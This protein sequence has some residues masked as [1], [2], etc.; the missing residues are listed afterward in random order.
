MTIQGRPPR[1]GDRCTVDDGRAGV[2]AA[3]GP[4]VCLI[5]F[6]GH[7]EQ[8]A[9]DRV[10]YSVA[11]TEILAGTGELWRAELAKIGELLARVDERLRDR[12]SPALERLDTIGTLVKLLPELVA[13]VALIADGRDVTSELR[14]VVA[15]VE[16][17]VRG[18]EA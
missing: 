12:E 15:K 17:I 4:T 8:V 7:L 9:T 11:I 2:I 14:D 1:A 10:R 18:V 5:D 6:L 3:Y 16:A 13:L